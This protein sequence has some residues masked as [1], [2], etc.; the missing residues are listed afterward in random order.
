MVRRLI[1]IS[2][3]LSG[4]GLGAAAAPVAADCSGPTIL[5]IDPAV[6]GEVI[7]IRGYAFGDNCYDTGGAPEGA[8]ALG[9]PVPDIELFI[10][11][12]DG[13]VMVARGSADDGYEFAVEVTVPPR[14]SPGP[15]RVI[16]RWGAVS[17]T[18]RIFEILD[19]PPVAEPPG[20]TPVES[21]GSVPGTAVEEPAVDDIT[22]TPRAP[23]PAAVDET[24]DGADRRV[25]GGLLV[26]VV[27]TVVVL[28]VV[29]PRRRSDGG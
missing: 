2:F 19:D 20:T 14:S 24:D 23:A 29:L 9:V 4:L 16:A 1:L 21:F 22:S 10:A 8:G 12:G 17:S 6:R 7:T 15:A 25:I 13:E 26:L 11:Q 5:P 3:V 28:A 18:E 27:V